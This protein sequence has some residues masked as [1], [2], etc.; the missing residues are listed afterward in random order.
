MRLSN[1][2][3][4]S[5]IGLSLGFG[6]P[7]TA[8]SRIPVNPAHSLAQAVPGKNLEDRLKEIHNANGQRIFSKADIKKLKKDGI[9]LEYVFDI[10]TIQDAQGTPI[11][12]DGKSTLSYI[13]EFTKLGITIEYARNLARITDGIGKPIFGSAGSLLLLGGNKIDLGYVKELSSIKDKNGASLFN[14]YN[15]FFC[16][17]DGVSIDYA[18]DLAS[19][20]DTKGESIFNGNTISEYKRIGGTVDFAKSLAS[21]V[22]VKGNPIFRGQDIVY[23]A[24]S[25]GTIEYA[26]R[27]A[28]TKDSVGNPVFNGRSIFKFKQIGGTL[29]QALDLASV[30]DANGN[31]ILD[32]FSI[33]RFTQLGLGKK[34]VFFYDT[35]KPNAVVIYPF[36]DWN[37]TFESENSVSLF[38]RIREKYDVLVR[39]ASQEQQVYDAID[40]VPN[41]YLLV[42]AGH[43]TNKVISLGENDLARMEP[44]KNDESYTIDTSD[45]EIAHHLQKL[46]PKG[47]IFLFS[48]S[49][50]A[51]GDGTSIADF[52]VHA[53]KGRRV[54]AATDSFGP[55]DVQIKF[56]YPFHVGIVKDG[57]DITYVR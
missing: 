32:G 47:T 14:A 7:S 37:W 11:Y 43:G 56:V 12:L 42:L 55:G 57:K 25:K 54:I 19:I 49:N 45:S 51:V 53:S 8:E 33:Y 31:P 35:K 16:H 4:A 13:S 46:N 34:D 18:K 26:K 1:R 30:R 15:I 40:I 23:Y 48:C 39:I 41:S 10:A 38:K 6:I 27:L 21:I 50:A 3:I 36:N 9:S 5:V 29:E 22:D 52:I 24:E 2:L 44:Q 28:A 20:T 17:N